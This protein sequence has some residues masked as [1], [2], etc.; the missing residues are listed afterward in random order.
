ML[1]ATLFPANIRIRS[2]ETLETVNVVTL[3]QELAGPV[4]AFV[5]SP[6][7]RRVLV[8]IGDQVQVFSALDSQFHAA[9]RNPFAGTAKPSFIQF[10]AKDHEVCICSAFGL[11]F[12]VFDLATSKA[13]EINNP[14]FH[15]ASSAARGFSF[16]PGT[17]HMAFLTRAGGKDVVSIHHPATREVQRSWHPDT[18]DAQALAWTTDGRWLVIRESPA[19]GHK[20]L[21]YTPDGNL[22]KAWIGRHGSTADGQ[23]FELGAGVKFCQLS[24]NAKLAALC[25][26]TRCICILD[27][28]AVTETVRLVHPTT[29]TPKDTLQVCVEIFSIYLKRISDR[30]YRSGKSKSVSHRQG[31]QL[32][33]SSEPARPSTHLANRQTAVLPRRNRA[34]PPPPL[35][36]RQLYLPYS[37]RNL[38][39]PFGFG[40]YRR[41]NYAPFL[42]FTRPCRTSVGIHAFEKR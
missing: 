37:W 34:V 33:L 12:A 21:F 15:H 22:F 27:M 25:D 5:W 8:A 19:Q 38:S 16:R 29:V 7:S 42:Y 32:M 14:K 26:H 39:A 6:S 23:D 36:H 35:T 11:K 2:V 4:S 41:R 20:V 1:I 18:V 13:A 30:F 31:L 10:G 3:P 28:T 40:M 9:I 24:P 17:S